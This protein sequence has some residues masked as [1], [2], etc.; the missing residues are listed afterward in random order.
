VTHPLR[1]WRKRRAL[2]AL[3]R[4]HP[5]CTFLAPA[6]IEQCAFGRH[7]VV[8]PGTDLLEV[9]LDDG[10]YVAARSALWR[11]R[12]G[13]YGAIGSE[14][15]IGLPRH[16][17]R[18]FVSIHPAFFSVANEGCLRS[19]VEALGFD[20]DPLPTEIG[21]DVWIGNRAI[22][23]GGVSIG[24]GAIVAAGSVV[25]K[26]VPPYAIVGGNPA[27]HI[28]DRFDEEDVRF[29]RALRWWD[30]SEE[31]LSALAGSFHSV[32]ALRRALQGAPPVP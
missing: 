3:R 9:S 11:V 6:R 1:W 23:P 24:D 21:H 13:R 12:A 32:A 19:F 2:T 18:D 14:V 20:E 4:E 29:L 22:V 7:V 5:T 26:D 17:A 30:W 16:P 8:H 27:R 28:R 10:T 31:R 25:T 15:L